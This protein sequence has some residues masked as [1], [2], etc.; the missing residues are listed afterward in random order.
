MERYGEDDSKKVRF[1]EFKI[2]V[3][4][5]QDK[6]DLLEAFEHVHNSNIDTDFVPVNQLAHVYLTP[7]RMGNDEVTNMII[8]DPK[9]F[10]RVNSIEKERVEMARLKRT[11]KTK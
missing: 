6:E 10:D 5:T 8:V 9:S 3:P 2:V 11:G 7:E 1:T 4:S